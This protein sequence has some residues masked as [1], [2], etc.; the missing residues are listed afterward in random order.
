MKKNFSVNI[1]GRIFHI[2]EDAY[3][4][5]SNYLGKLRLFFQSGEGSG[6]IIADIEMR[7]AELLEKQ[8]AQGV[9]AITLQHVEE[10]IRNIGE[11]EQFSEGSSPAP[12]IKTGGKLYRDVDNRQVGGVAA[13]IA[14]WFGIDPTWIRILFVVVAISYGIGAFIYLALW[15]ILP[16]A[17]STTEKLEMQRQP[18]NLGNFRNE[19]SSA[20]SGIQRTGSSLLQGIGSVLRFVTE[21]VV[22]TFTFVLKLLVRFAGALLLLMALGLLVSI[23][24][25]FLVREQMDSIRYHLDTTTLVQMFQWMLPSAGTRWL[26]YLAILFL[27]LGLVSLMILGGLKMLVKWP[28]VRWH[29]F[30]IIGLLV[31]GGILCGVTALVKITHASDEQ[32]SVSDS[33][34]YGLKGG[35]IHLTS[36]SSDRETYW[37]PL[38]S[39]GQQ[40]R[41]QD[42][43]GDIDLSVRPSSG[44]SVLITVISMAS[45]S[46]PGN[47]RSYLENIRYSYSLDDTLLTLP[48]YFFI[49]KADGL[50]YQKADVIV[51]LPVNTEV[52][53]DDNIEWKISYKDYSDDNQGSGLYVMTKTG[54]TL[55][56][57][58]VPVSDS[59]R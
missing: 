3:E 32:V 42:V 1:G 41:V 48:P 29:M 33:R 7:I 53:L 14:A 38:K 4:C 12:R 21:L 2:D 19:V 56:D 36:G 15:F 50:R 17:R 13:G 52:F 39:D 57:Q 37:A 30:A 49:P 10:V 9:T 31:L 45:A 43:L 18:V 34:S 46:F 23:I 58:P 55:K 40:G 5:L 27:G 11:P 8:T 6:E 22:R 20:A 28:P 54:L 24:P 51:G 44:D 16:P 35:R 59:I 25:A 47:D 26:A